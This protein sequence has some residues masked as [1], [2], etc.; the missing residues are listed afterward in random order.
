MVNLRQL[1]K[2]WESAPSFSDYID[3]DKFV[4]SHTFRTKT[5]QIGCVLSVQGID[6]ESVTRSHLDSLTARLQRTFQTFTP[7]TRVYQY[8]LR[9]SRPEIPHRS[10]GDGVSAKIIGYRLDDL[11]AKRDSLYENHAYL[12][13]LSEMPTAARK[14]EGLLAAFS[15]SKVIAVSLAAQ[16]ETRAKLMQQVSTFLTSTEDFA[17]VE[18]LDVEGAYSLFRHLLNPDPLIRKAPLVDGATTW[19]AFFAADSTFRAQATHLELDD[20]FV[21]V[22]TL[23]ALPHNTRPNMLAQLLRV[24]GNFH[25]VTSWTPEH[26]RETIKHADAI[27][28][29]NE[30]TKQRATATPKRQLGPARVSQSKEALSD[31]LEQ[32]GKDIT[33]NGTHYGFYSLTVVLYDRD[34]EALEHAVAEFLTAAQAIG[35]TLIVESDFANLAFLATIPGAHRYN[36]RAKRISE[37]N[38]ADLSFFYTLDTGNI[39]NAQLKDEYLVAL[40]TRDDTLYYLNLHSGEVGHTAMFGPTSTGKSFTTNL[41]LAQASKYDPFIQIIDMGG[42][43]KYLCS[44]LNGNYTNFSSTDRSFNLN[45]FRL[46]KTA[47]NLDFLTTFVCSLI[48]HGGGSA[49]N[50]KEKNDIFQKIE[51]L[52]AIDNPALRTLTTLS[53]T[54]P[55]YLSDRL[56]RWLRGGQYGYIFDNPEG[57]D[58]LTTSRVQVFNFDGFDEKADF[59][60]PVLFYILHRS[61]ENVADPA[62]LAVMKVFVLDEAFRFFKNERIREYV[63]R[64]LTTWR[65]HNALVFFC[66]QQV[67]HIEDTGIVA[68]VATNC[69]TFFFLANPTLDI[70]KYVQVFKMQPDTAAQIKTLIPRYEML[71]VKKPDPA[72]RSASELT[73]KV[74]R[75]AVSPIERWVYANSA[76]ENIR[77]QKALARFNGDI[78]S[79]L[80]WLAANPNDEAA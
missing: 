30:A 35:L 63:V 23:K 44:L 3:L 68:D 45:P 53:R 5:G 67:E 51:Q 47:D 80:R 77:R 76:N 74:L 46:Q 4:D 7:G 39:Y 26:Q 9:S 25:V 50:D 61:T 40:P 21:K 79:A 10:Y 36:L 1:L 70:E 32:V 41:L 65:K 62:Q 64:G 28:G 34:P 6:Y 52:Y 43:Y 37:A 59:L 14:A 58:S 48:E 33:L 2:G 27:I 69:S 66:T 15:S 29:H 72:K 54:L 12:V 57:T 17:A 22:L 55:E 13:V 71:C 8:Y 42:S 78:D 11:E 56:V 75:V 73:A 60:E 38:A 18:L 49:L 24:P 19:P 31:Q 20:Y 16:E